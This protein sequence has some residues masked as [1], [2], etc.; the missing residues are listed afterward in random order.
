MNDTNIHN[1]LIKLYPSYKSYA[2]YTELS[3]IKDN[4]LSKKGIYPVIK[5]KYPD[6]F[7]E[8]F[9]I[10][11]PQSN[12]DKIANTLTE[13]LINDWQEIIKDIEKNHNTYILI[14]NI[15]KKEYKRILKSGGFFKNKYIQF[16]LT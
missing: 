11:I 5:D 7:Y 6:W 15:Y 10:P 16:I 1:N 9:T 12:I 2:K 8:V 14:K 4:S 13:G 3:E